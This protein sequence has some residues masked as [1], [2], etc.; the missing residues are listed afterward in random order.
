L[1]WAEYKS[2]WLSRALSSIGLE[3]QP[4]IF[5]LELVEPSNN[6]PITL[7]QNNSTIT[8]FY[9]ALGQFLSYRL[10]LREIHPERVLYLAV[11]DDVYQSFFQLEFT[12]VAIAEYQL[13]VVVYNATQEEIVQWKK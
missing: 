4:G 3:W 9:A 7:A 2:Y 13:L 10:G 5:A 6:S 11:P 8:D 1:E 12:Q